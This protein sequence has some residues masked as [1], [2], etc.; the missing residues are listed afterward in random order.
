MKSLLIVALVAWLVTG[1]VAAS[2][3]GYFNSNHQVT[4]RSASNLG[5]TVVA[6]PFNYAGADP[7]VGCHA[8]RNRQVRTPHIV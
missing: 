4:C 2:Q 3:R 6:G 7:N 1:T 5:L 8:L